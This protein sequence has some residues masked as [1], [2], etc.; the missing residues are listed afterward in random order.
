MAD[1]EL[2]QVLDYILN[3][4][5]EK[6]I[7]AVAAAVVRRRRDLALFGGTGKLPDPQKMARDLAGQINTGA[8][9]EGLTDTVRSMAE[10]IIR[11]EAPELG[12]QEIAE[13]TRAWIPGEKTGE[14]P[15]ERLPRD[16]LAAMTAQF[17]SFSLGRM[18][19][20]ED[21]ELRSSLGA[22]PDRYWK[23]F[24]PVIRRIIKDFL[25]GEMTEGE[26][27]TQLKTALALDAGSAT[28]PS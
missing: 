19:E 14:E 26:F 18:G 4:C 20:G 13:L 6:A 27:N 17:V 2:V 12:D 9:I 23:A 28:G 3:R 8:S 25:R 16:L 24:P 11:R 10:R 5:D 22:W 7:D 1:P 15:G 21:R